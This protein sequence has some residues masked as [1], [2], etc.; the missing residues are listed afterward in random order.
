MP[1]FITNNTNEQ[2]AEVH[3]F[4]KQWHLR[5]GCGGDQYTTWNTFK[6]VLS[7][8]KLTIKYV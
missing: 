6:T 4:A 3:H 1:P 5:P 7:S 2:S 8:E